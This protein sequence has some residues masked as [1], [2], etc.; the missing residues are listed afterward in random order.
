M[1]EKDGLLAAG[2]A[3][4]EKIMCLEGELRYERI[5]NETLTKNNEA[6]TDRNN[7][8]EAKLLEVRQHIEQQGQR[9]E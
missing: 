3:L 6:L 1:E 2:R 8:L 7:K 4:G 9:A 5:R